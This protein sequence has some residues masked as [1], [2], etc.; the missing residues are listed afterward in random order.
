MTRFA[1]L[2]H[3]LPPSWSGQSVILEKLLRDVDPHSYCLLSSRHAGLP[4]DESGFIAPLAARTFQVRGTGPFRHISRVSQKAD[5]ALRLVA[6][7]ASILSH[8]RR[9]KI[10]TLVACT[11]DLLDLPAAWLACRLG[12]MRLVV[13][14]FDDY[15]T[16]WVA[17][18]HRA[19]AE[20]FEPLV[21]AGAAAIIVPNEAL[22]DEIAT[23]HQLDARIVRNAVEI[24]D[25]ERR[26]HTWPQGDVP[27]RIVYTGAIYE[28]HF[29]AFRNLTTALEQIG[30]PNFELHIYTAQSAERIHAEGIRSHTILH[31]HLP[32]DEVREVQRG[33]D[34]LFLPLGFETTIPDVIRTSAPGKTGEYLASG[35]PTLVHAPPDSFLSKYFTEHACG[36]VVD[37]PDPTALCDA[38]RRIDADADA[39][40]RVADNALLRAQADF[41]LEEA[42]R[43]FLGEIQTPPEIPK[44]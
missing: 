36:F 38:I 31:G 40:D 10:S 17:P 23:R 39:R 37:T 3:A 5:G 12:G 30:H 1:V 41:G 35:R 7:V 43:N 11:G 13:H 16:Q 4:D 29:D 2:S 14:L 15:R 28:A 25:I 42:R 44:S 33:A 22:R 24:T 21:L 6:R 34:V 8:A 9:E 26:E 19:F 27:V 18:G 20:A 32:P